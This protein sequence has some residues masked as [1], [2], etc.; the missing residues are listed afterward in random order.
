MEDDWPTQHWSQP[1]DPN[2]PPPSLGGII[3]FIGGISFMGALMVFIGFVDGDGEAL[4]WGELPPSSR[5]CYDQQNDAEGRVGNPTKHFDVQKGLAW[6]TK[7]GTFDEPAAPAD[8]RPR[9]KA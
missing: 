6:W 3:F 2:A 4:F 5:P 8:V 7:R 1:D 9:V